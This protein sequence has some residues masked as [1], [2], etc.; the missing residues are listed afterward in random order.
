MELEH[1][2]D[3]TA[4]KTGESG[5]IEAGDVDIIVD[6]GAGVGSRK[7]AKYLK[8]SGFARSTGT[9]NGCDG[10]GFDVDIDASQHFNVAER[11]EYISR[12]NHY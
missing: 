11:F 12:R 3:I 9:D 7:G 6:Y 1:K 4:A 2:T 8:Q 10:A 5:I